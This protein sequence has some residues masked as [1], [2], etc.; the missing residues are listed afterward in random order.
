MCRI[1]TNDAT[2][3]LRLADNHVVI[4]NQAIK[5][6]KDIKPLTR[7]E[8]SW[9]LP[10]RFASGRTA[11]SAD[12]VHCSYTASLARKHTSFC[13]ISI[14]EYCFQLSCKKISLLLFTLNWPMRGSIKVK[15]KAPLAPLLP[16]LPLIT[17]GGFISQVAPQHV[18]GRHRVHAQHT[19]QQHMLQW[20]LE[21]FW[22]VNELLARTSAGEV[23]GSRHWKNP[24]APVPP[25]W[26]LSSSQA[27]LINTLV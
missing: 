17:W 23:F 15:T 21:L 2:Q 25:L 20:W 7:V 11:P 5:N 27:D 9:L 12:P 16:L 22:N 26:Y 19:P 1:K 3:S 8:I 6:I 24:G 13:Q 18:R 4:M 14:R 10:E